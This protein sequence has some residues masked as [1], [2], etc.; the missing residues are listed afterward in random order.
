MI[1]KKTMSEQ[2]NSAG[3]QMEPSTE[4]FSEVLLHSRTIFYYF[5]NQ[6]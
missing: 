6:L 5:M 2:K 1:R 4:N 3:Q